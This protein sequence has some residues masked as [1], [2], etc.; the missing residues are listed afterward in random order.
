MI[1]EAFSICKGLETNQSS[2]SIILEDVAV[3]KDK[4]NN[5]VEITLQMACDYN[6][7]FVSIALL[8]L[9]SHLAFSLAFN[10]LCTQE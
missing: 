2:Y 1:V 4:N 7:G 9:I 3:S 5:T 6:L 10:K 8:E